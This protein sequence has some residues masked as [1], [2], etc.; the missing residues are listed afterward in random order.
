MSQLRLAKETDLRSFP[1]CHAVVIDTPPITQCQET[2]IVAPTVDTT[3]GEYT[4]TKA[5]AF[6]GID[7][8]GKKVTITLST[9][10]DGTYNI[11]SNTDD[12][13]TTDHEFTTTESIATATCHD[14]AQAYLTRNEASFVRFVQSLG[15]AHTTLNGQLY[16]DVETGPLAAAC[17]DTYNPD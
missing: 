5:G 11:I 6:A 8:A 2:Q 13:L 9:A 3:S 16:T 15:N 12:V 14:D 1:G 10:D 4:V 17:S 7:L